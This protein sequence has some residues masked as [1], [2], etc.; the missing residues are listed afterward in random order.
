[1]TVA[2]GPPTGALAVLQSSPFA[3]LQVDT[4]TVAQAALVLAV[5]YVLAQLVA[6]SLSAVSERAG[7]R[8]ITV[9]VFIP[10]I[11]FVIYAVA[12]A[13]I[14]GGI[15]RLSSTQLV[16]AGGL[17]GAALGFGIK[18]LFA[19]V[20]GGLVVVFE[21]PYRVGDKVTLGNHYGEVTDVGLR[22][23]RLVTPDDTEV[24][25]PNLSIFGEPVA[26]AN[27]G[28]AELLA[29]A[30]V[31]VAPSADRERAVEIVRE[32]AL[33]SP[34]VRLSGE[35]PVTVIVEDGPH[36]TTIR[37]KAYVADL[38]DEFPFTSDMT[39]R[40]L[41]GFDEAGIERP[42]FVPDEDEP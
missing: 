35:H 12:V 5:A 7:D 4:G 18:D 29:V 37:G 21:R 10:L 31:H 40:A 16:A 33:T 19:S 41:A 6:A 2:V 20:I 25:V 11:R 27:T 30:E 34:Y 3:G 26:N 28:A 32:A 23:T 38:R 1:M 22:A 9:K 8:R 15:F 39:R 14:L 24:V 36:Y 13:S 17:L 42:R